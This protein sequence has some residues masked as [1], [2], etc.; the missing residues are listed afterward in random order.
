MSG[1]IIAFTG[2]VIVGVIG[3]IIFLRNS[4][5]KWYHPPERKRE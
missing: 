2:G 1:E 4:L 5:G 3:T